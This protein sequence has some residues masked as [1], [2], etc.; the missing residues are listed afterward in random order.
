MP[1]YAA[2]FLYTLS[3]LLYL[4]IQWR[5]RS[6]RSANAEV[7]RGVLGVKWL[8]GLLCLNTWCQRSWKHVGL[9]IA[10]WVCHSF[11]L[12]LSV[13]TV[14]GL[15]STSV[16]LYDIAVT[17]NEVFWCRI[18]HIPY[19]SH[20]RRTCGLVRKRNK[21]VC[22]AA[23]TMSEI[24]FYSKCLLFFHSIYYLVFL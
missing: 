18:A 22:A 23:I 3:K 6:L 15:P 8:R 2:A 7:T 16:Q 12:V 5:C 13:S 24:T 19:Y 17:S 11:T 9:Q 4:T 10:M 20:G 21:I 1:S 14:E